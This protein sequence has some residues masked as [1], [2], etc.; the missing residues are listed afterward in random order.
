MKVRE[1]KD[2]DLLLILFKYNGKYFG[3]FCMT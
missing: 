1:G 3:I 2:M